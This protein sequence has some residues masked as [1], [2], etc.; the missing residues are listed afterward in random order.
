MIWLRLLSPVNSKTDAKNATVSRSVLY[1]GLEAIQIRCD[2]KRHA[3]GGHRYGTAPSE[4]NKRAIIKTWLRELVVEPARRDMPVDLSEQAARPD[5]RRRRA[6]DAS[7]G[8]G[9]SA[10]VTGTE[11]IVQGSVPDRRAGSAIDPIRSTFWVVAHVVSIC[12]DG[13]RKTCDDPAR[14]HH[15]RLRRRV[16]R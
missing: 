5:R 6:R 2:I 8:A 3:N 10:S 4:P 16:D 14:S 9:R 7:L 11:Y 15:F 12:S 1:Y 13:A